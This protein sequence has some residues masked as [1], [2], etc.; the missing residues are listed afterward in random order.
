M[1]T[2]DEMRMLDFYAPCFGVTIDELMERA[3]K[4]L[5]DIISKMIKKTEPVLV[6]CYHGNNGGDGLCAARHLAAKGYSVRVHFLGKPERM[7]PETRRQWKLL[8]KQILVQDPVYRDYALIVDALLG[9]GNKG[10]LKGDL[11]KA[12]RSMI[13]KRLVAVDIPS[14]SVLK[15]GM[16]VS[17]HDRKSWVSGKSVVV[18]IGLP[19]QLKQMVTTMIPVKEERFAHKGSQGRVLVVGGSE[20]YSTAP[21]LAASAVAALR[22]GVDWVEVAAPEKVAWT[23]NCISPDLVTTKLKGEEITKDHVAAIHKIPHDVML[24]GNGMGKN[25]AIPPLLGVS[26]RKVVDADAVKMADLREIRNALLTPHRGEAKTLFAHSGIKTTVLDDLVTF[27]KRL[28]TGKTALDAFAMLKKSVNR[29]QLK[30]G[31][32]VLLIKGPIDLIISK[33]QW[34]FNVTG[35]PRMAVAGT[36]DV[37]AGLCA[38]FAAQMSLFDAGCSAAFLIGK[39]GEKQKGKFVASDLVR[40]ISN[41]I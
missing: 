26:K 11:S 28:L 38:G 31:S 9:T 25:E 2:S 4:G 16:T 6:V 13:G 3:G 8:P 7:K 27:E 35:V 33:K 20:H 15:P 34:K 14:A 21:F 37:L 19:K 36:G 1:I 23:I 41:F 17:F 5:A 12:V 18:D 32:N 39:L 30:L 22:S 24:I 29:I 40:A 10:I